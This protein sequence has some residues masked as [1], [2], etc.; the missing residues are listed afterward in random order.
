MLI[1]TGPGGVVNNLNFDNKFN[2]ISG[3]YFF[4]GNRGVAIDAGV[5]YDPD[6]ITQV[7]ASIIDLGFIRWKKNANNFDATGNYSFNGT[8]LNQFQTNADQSGFIR[9]L[10]DSISRVFRASASSYFTLTPVKIYGGITRV[11]MPNLRAGAMTRIEIYNRHIMP[12][13]SLSMNYTPFP[14]VAASLSYT[15]MNNKYNQIGA[16]IA[17]GNRVAQF[18][19][20]ADNIPVRYTKVIRLPDNFPKEIRFPFIVP[21]NARMFSLRLGVNLLF[22][23]N[24]KENKFRGK[25][26]RRRDI[27]PAYW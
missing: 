16:G 19:L 24:K 4:N 2:N 1:G 3:D 27:C 18:Y 12:S 11:I 20:V 21:Y 9:A 10:E 6:E 17:L 7:T 15:I 22:G 26:F 5:V 23:C 13:L 14:S 25:N 8:D